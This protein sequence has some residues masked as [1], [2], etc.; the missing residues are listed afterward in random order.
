M[1]CSAFFETATDALG[2]AAVD[3][4]RTSVGGQCVLEFYHPAVVSALGSDGLAT[5]FNR[6][7][8]VWAPRGQQFAVQLRVPDTHDEAV[9]EALASAPLSFDR[10]DHR[11]VSGPDGDLVTVLHFGLRTGEVDPVTVEATLAAVGEA[12]TP[13]TER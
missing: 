5:S 12:L 13:P 11:G 8:V 4:S 1:D 2:E 9:R 10:T 6:S 7:G 3:P